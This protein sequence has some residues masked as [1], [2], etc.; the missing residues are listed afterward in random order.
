MRKG[1]MSTEEL[2]SVQCFL[3]PLFYVKAVWK[4]SSGVADDTYHSISGK[5]MEAQ[6][7]RPDVVQ[8]AHAYSMRAKLEGV[9]YEAHIDGWLHE[10]NETRSR[11][12]IWRLRSSKSYPCRHSLFSKRL[13]T[14]GRTS[15]STNQGCHTDS[16]QLMHGC[17]AAHRAIGPMHYG[18][19]FRLPV[20]R[21]DS[22]VS[23][24][25]S[26]CSSRGCRTPSGCAGR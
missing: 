21:N 1:G 15:R 8:I 24:E 14:I 3:K 23:R 19:A 12:Q 9:S 6:R 5:M 20:Q 11:S 17:T 26:V 4:G 16:C 10:Y 22:S 2:S 18:C 25:R 13:R 7:P